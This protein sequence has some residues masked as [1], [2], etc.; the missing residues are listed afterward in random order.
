[1]TR[2]AGDVDHQIAGCDGPDAVVHRLGAAQHRVDA[3]D[4]LAGRERL[5][6]V[7]VRAETQPRDPV[8]LLA[9]GGEEDHCGAIGACD[10]Q[11]PHHLEP[12]DPGQH[13]VEHDELGPLA[14]GGR[15]RLLAVVG[16]ARVVSRALQV[17][18]DD[19]GDRLLVVDDEHSRTPLAVQV[20]PGIVPL[21][22]RFGARFRACSHTV[23]NRAHARGGPFNRSSRRPLKKSRAAARWSGAA[24]RSA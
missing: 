5:D 1:M 20:H 9:T 11:A 10:A 16:D 14:F 24:S 22:G 3:R 6:D 19:L 4:E 17:A 18:R 12:A 21:S 7:V 13:Q 15:E 23:Q 8:G 2:R